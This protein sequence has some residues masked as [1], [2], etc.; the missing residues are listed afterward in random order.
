MSTQKYASMAAKD[1]RE[2]S[3][4]WEGP[5][6]IT[7]VQFTKEAPDN[8]EAQG[9]PI[10]G[11]MSILADGDGPEDERKQQ[12]SYSLGAK[13]GDE[14]TISEDGFGLIPI[15]GAVAS[16]RKGTKWD[17]LKCS[18]ELEGVSSSVFENGDMSKLIGL[19]GQFKR[20]NDPERS[21]NNDNRKQKDSK[22]KPQ[23]LVCVNVLS[24]PGEKSTAVTR[25]TATGG[26][27]Q[28]AGGDSTLPEGDLDTVTAEYLQQVLTS[29]KDKRIQRSQ[30]TLAVNKAAMKDPRRQDIARRAADEAFLAS[31]AELNIVIYDPAA[32]PQYVTLA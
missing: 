6:V 4:L 25:T 31:L 12:Q 26:A 7:N 23:T 21:F 30:L 1:T 29:A 15:D 16:T 10:F 8:Y 24:L 27:V 17:T 2:A 22:F 5:G 28:A 20:V 3:S 19:H 18:F 14:F 9:N 13:A 32:K 11:I